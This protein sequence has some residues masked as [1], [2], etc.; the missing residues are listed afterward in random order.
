VDSSRD[1]PNARCGEPSAL[2]LVHVNVMHG[3][4]DQ[5]V[6]AANARGATFGNPDEPPQGAINAKN[7]Q[8]LTDPGPQSP[9]LGSQFPSAQSPPP[10]DVGDLPQFWASFNNAPNA[11]KMAAGRAR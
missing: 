9:A 5:I 2:D 4:D 11:L 3:D 8:S 7:P 1:H 6:P 10:T